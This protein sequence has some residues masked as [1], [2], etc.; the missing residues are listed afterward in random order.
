MDDTKKLLLMAAV[1]IR[2][3]ERTVPWSDLPGMY[4]VDGL[5]RLEEAVG[6]KVTLDGDQACALLGADLQSGQAAFVPLADYE[7]DHPR[8]KQDAVNQL[9]ASI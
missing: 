8:A 2:N 6:L 5:D 3:L 7:S 4:P 1:M 9:W